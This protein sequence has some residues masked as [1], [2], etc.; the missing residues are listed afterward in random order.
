MKTGLVAL[1]VVAC[2]ALSCKAQDEVQYKADKYESPGISATILVWT[3]DS[4]TGKLL[5]ERNWYIGNDYLYAAV[6]ESELAV[7]KD[8]LY[9]DRL[10]G[11]PWVQAFRDK[12]IASCWYTGS[13]RPFY[14]LRLDYFAKFQKD[15]QVVH[16]GELP[17]LITRTDKDDEGGKR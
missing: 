17:W 10:V 11:W 2:L 8:K 5:G 3:A 1:L 4:P 15:I 13:P 9:G 16:K 7:I 6:S 14:A 12:I